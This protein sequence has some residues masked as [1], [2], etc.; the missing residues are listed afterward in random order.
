MVLIALSS[1]T[2]VRLTVKP[3]GN[4]I[5]DVAGRDRA[6]KLA[7]VA[8]LAQQHEGLAV[9]LARD[10][11][12]FFLALEIARFQLRALGFEIVEVGFGRAQRLLLRQQEVAGEAVLHLH[13]IAHLAELFDAFEQDHLHGCLLL[14]DVGKQR[15]EAR[16]LDGVG[17][18]AL[19][20][21]ATPR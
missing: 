20:L 14:H 15:H 10:L 9:E 4:R 5:G 13:H 16:A 17:E 19:L 18:F 11:F 21:G 3:P 6:I 2:W 1:G 8:G 7:A 12:G